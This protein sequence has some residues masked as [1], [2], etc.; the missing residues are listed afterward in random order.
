V[1][2]SRQPGEAA[3]YRVFE[4]EEEFQTAVESYIGERLA[5]LRRALRRAER[6][7]DELQREVEE[8]RRLI[9]TGGTRL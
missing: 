1:A 7:R 4:T 3:P 2:G 5:K 8:L 9:H 6:E